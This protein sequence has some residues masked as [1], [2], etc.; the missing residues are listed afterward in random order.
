LTLTAIAWGSLL[1]CARVTI[2]YARE[3]VPQHLWQ[4]AAF[5]R[6]NQYITAVWGRRF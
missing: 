2:Q 1:A 5:I 6:V 4:T 3:Q